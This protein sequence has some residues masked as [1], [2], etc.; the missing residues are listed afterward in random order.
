MFLGGLG[1]VEA[2]TGILKDE[3]G[4]PAQSCRLRT[5]TR[6]PFPV[7]A[8]NSRRQHVWGRGQGLE[9]AGPPCAKGYED[10]GTKG[11]LSEVLVT[12]NIWAPGGQ[13][14]S[15][16]EVGPPSGLLWPVSQAAGVS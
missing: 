10:A 11:L 2:G 7:R 4:A 3:A 15:W 14:A 12:Q 16:A 13:R 8:L 9:G 6:M 1:G 5:R